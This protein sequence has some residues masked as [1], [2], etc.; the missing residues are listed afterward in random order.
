[1]PSPPQQSLLARGVYVLR[2]VADL[3]LLGVIG[4]LSWPVVA[5][6][7][8]LDGRH[9]VMNGSFGS[10]RLVNTYGAFGSVGEARYELARPRS[11]ESPQSPRG[12]PRYFYYY[13]Y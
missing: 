3:A 5:N 1:M 7:L 6:L 4:W 11:R 12:R 10:F 2:R 8:Q 9:Q 13:Q